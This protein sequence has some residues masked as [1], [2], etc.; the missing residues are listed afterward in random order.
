MRELVKALSEL[1]NQLVSNYGVSLNEAM[2]L[3]CISGDTLTASTISDT[4]GLTPS[5]T[6]KVIRSAENKD[7]IC[8]ALGDKDRRQMRF[9]LTDNGNRLLQKIKKEEITVPEFI[10]PLFNEN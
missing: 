9:S 2:L 10:R 1:E 3:C 4:I 5:N 8:R 6:S 7:L